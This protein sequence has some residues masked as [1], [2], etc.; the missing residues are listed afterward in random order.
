MPT[1]AE[2]MTLRAP[3]FSLDPQVS[4]YLEQAELET[5]T[6]YGDLRNKAVFL[7][8]AHWMALAARGGGGSSSAPGAIK[9]EKEGDL[10]RSYGAIGTG[11]DIDL[12]LSQTTWGVELY[13]L[14]RSC[15]ILPRTRQVP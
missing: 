3:A 2:Y 11:G 12:F 9:S 4:D 6:N 7:L 14:Q 10:A 5:G 1:P 15:F 13:N 8:A